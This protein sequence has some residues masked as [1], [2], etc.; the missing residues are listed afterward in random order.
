[1]RRNDIRSTPVGALDRLLPVPSAGGSYTTGARI[2]AQ[3]WGR[4]EP[5]MKSP[6]TRAIMAPLVVAALTMSACTKYDDAPPADEEIHFVRNTEFSGP[7][8]RVFITG[9]DGTRL[10]V[11]TADDAVETRRGSTPI[12]GHDARSWTFVKDKDEGTS[13]VYAL[14]SW[15]G[16]DPRDYLMAG[17]WAEFPDQHPPD[18]SFSDSDQYAIVD[19]PETDPSSPPRLPATGQATYV[20]QAGGLY[21]Y[22]PGSDWGEDEGTRLIDEWEGTMTLTAD[23]A[24]GT[25]RGCVGCVGE[26]AT[27]RAHFGV[28]LGAEAS[29]IEFVGADYEMHLGATPINP[30]GTFEHTDVTIRH[31]ERTITQS[32]GAWGGSLSNIPDQAGDPRIAAGFVSAEFEESDD[33]AGAFVGAFV[34]LSEPFRAAQ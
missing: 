14:V 20:G 7:H 11:N 4:M 31:P 13:V 12:P 22:I 6:S 8:L 17:W 18:L 30:D 9:R 10:S 24:D 33:S 26:I 34:T 29:D 16:D 28:F 27:G 2:A 23:F 1:M 25:L 32:A 5:D 21:A 19:G 3:A 15:D